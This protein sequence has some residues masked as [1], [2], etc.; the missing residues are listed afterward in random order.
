MPSMGLQE[1]VILFLIVLLIFGPSNLPKVGK[2]IGQ[3]IREFKNAINGLGSAIEQEDAE[4]KKQEKN[5][6]AQASREPASEVNPPQ[7]PQ[8]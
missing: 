7:P 5:V 8:G 1:W 2:A 3:G 4:R 6:A